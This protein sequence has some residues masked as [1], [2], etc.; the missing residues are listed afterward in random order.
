MTVMLPAPNPDKAQEHDLL[1]VSRQ[2]VLNP[3][4]DFKAGSKALLPKKL[5]A[6][7]SALLAALANGPDDDVEMT[8]REC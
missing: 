5:E 7:R 6:V 8:V 2:C 3:A 4:E 1:K